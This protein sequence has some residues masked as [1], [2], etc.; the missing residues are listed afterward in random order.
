MTSN[1][2]APGTCTSCG[3]PLA[4]RA[5]FC[6]HCG[7]RVEQVGSPPTSTG[8]AA[9]PAAAPPSP[10]PAPAPA[11]RNRKATGAILVLLVV[12]LLV[13]AGAAVATILLDGDEP[14]QAG[15]A[16]GSAA[17]VPAGEA[18]SEAGTGQAE[19]D[20]GQA[21]SGSGPTGFP[22]V[23]ETEMAGEIQA[24]LLAFH[25]DVVARRFQGAWALLSPRKRRQTERED[26]YRGW[27][28]AQASLSPYLSPAGL[29][30]RIDALEDEG[31]AR[32]LVAG[33]DWSAPG[34]PCSEWSGLTW[35]KYEGGAWAYDPGYSTTPERERSWKPR[36]SEL[37]GASC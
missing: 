16:P 18:L 27:A 31:V 1:E 13:G 10:G 26:G 7:T 21:G 24:V 11:Q 32:V 25:E 2:I 6:R 36:Y 9:Q 17:T 22:A 14:E 28:K 8:P 29:T 19:S 34:S 35:A 33:M 3:R 23:G 30:V 5:S 4:A 15:P 12:G 20:T 37:L